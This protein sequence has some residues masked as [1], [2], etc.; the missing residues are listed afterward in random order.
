MKEIQDKIKYNF[1]KTELIELALT[2]RSA[3]KK[4][5]EKL[6]FLGDSILQTIISSSLYENNPN[7]S[8]GQLTQARAKLVCKESLAEIGKE[9]KLN[10]YVIL[11]SCEIKNG[12]IH[13]KSILANTL[14]AIIGA[15]YL[16]SDF[17][18]TKDIVIDLYGNKIN[19]INEK[20]I[21]KDAKTKLQEIMQEQKIK[22]PEYKLIK[23]DGMDHET[24][25]T[26]SCC[27]PQK[28]I[29]SIA[30]SASIKQ[31]EQIAANKILEQIIGQH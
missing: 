18:Q 5:N 4:N 22:L 20:E 6:E 1:K 2:H 25:F 13:K 23:K 10:E 19:E 14:E 26:V 7:M 31:A 29:E 9:L 15:I 30:S 21:Y 28:S 17:N 3:S 27:I 12:G 24:T 11:G 16:D 8:E